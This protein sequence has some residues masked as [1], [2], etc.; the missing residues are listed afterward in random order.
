MTANDLLK[1]AVAE[2]GNL[3][4]G[5]IFIV[6]DLFKGYAWNR[7][8]KNDRMKVGILF[9][10]EATSGVLA[11]VVEVIEKSTANQQKYKKK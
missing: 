10:N 1:N 4:S 11:N 8:E 2:V 3:Q 9:L 5:E 6:R 7:E